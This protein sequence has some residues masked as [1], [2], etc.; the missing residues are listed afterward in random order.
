MA[1]K[2]V[3]FNKEKSRRIAKWIILMIIFTVAS[4][5][6]HDPFH[7]ELLNILEEQRTWCI[8]SY[9]AFYRIFNSV[10]LI[11]HFLAPFLINVISAVA[12]VIVT[13]RQRSIVRKE[14]TYRQHMLEQ[15]RWC[16]HLLISPCILIL[17]AIPRLIISLLSNCVQSVRSP[18]LLLIGYFVSFVPSILNFFVFVLPSEH[19]RD[20]YRATMKQLRQRCCFR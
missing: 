6:L 5:Q 3:S 17:L 8:V 19:Y 14:K 15:L 13:A 4:S 7:R 18:W 11:F 2:G 16:H 10:I 12:I 20:E 9:S 1:L